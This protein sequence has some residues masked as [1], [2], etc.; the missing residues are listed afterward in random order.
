VLYEIMII[1]QQLHT[2][3]QTQKQAAR[4]KDWHLNVW[5]L[6]QIMK[7]KQH[8]GALKALKTVCHINVSAPRFAVQYFSAS[9]LWGM[10]PPVRIHNVD[11]KHTHTP[12]RPRRFSSGLGTMS[13]GRS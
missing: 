1:A 8:F 2:H 3:T 9:P 12:H 5:Q 10:V 13:M 6:V 11:S 4:G 7:M